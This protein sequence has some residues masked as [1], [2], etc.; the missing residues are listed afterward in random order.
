M[1]V[2]QILPEHQVDGW[3]LAAQVRGI[4]EAKC[5]GEMPSTDNMDGTARPVVCAITSGNENLIPHGWAYYPRL[6]T[7]VK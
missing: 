6:C 7:H 5:Y 2:I 4:G 1:R 3:E